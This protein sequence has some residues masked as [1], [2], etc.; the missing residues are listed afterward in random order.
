MKKTVDT[1]AGSALVWWGDFRRT[2]DFLE[3]A[4][5]TVNFIPDGLE[6]ALPPD[7]FF[8]L[9]RFIDIPFVPGF[10]TFA[11]RGSFTFIALIS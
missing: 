8:P 10:L 5:F 4:F 7:A 9:N 6:A 2:A 3:V 11:I 1:P